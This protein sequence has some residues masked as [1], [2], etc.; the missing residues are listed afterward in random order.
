MPAAPAAAPFL[1]ATE[2][3]DNILRTRTYDITISYDKYYQ[4]PRVFLFGY[5]EVPPCAR[6]PC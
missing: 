5:D 4:T 2:P 6:C 3:E 1:R